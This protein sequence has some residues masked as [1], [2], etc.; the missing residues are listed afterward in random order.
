[1]RTVAGTPTSTGAQV[2]DALRWAAV[3]SVGLAMSA[4]FVVLGL[5]L[6]T[7]SAPFTGA[8][9]TKVMAG[10]VLAPAVA[11]VVLI[12]VHHGMHERLRWPT[13][14]AS[15]WLAALLWSLALAV[16]DGGNGLA[17]PVA[18][19]T[20]YLPDARSLHD[21]IA[22]LRAFVAQSGQHTFATRQHPPGPVLLLWAVRP[23]G[24][25]R[26]TTIGIAITM[27]GALA[28]P[29]VASSVRPLC[30]E[31]AARRLV[32]A[33]A[34]APWAVW[35]AVSMD[36]VTSSLCAGFICCGV[37][38]GEPHRSRWWAVA[39]GLL[40]GVAAL[41]SYSVV[42]MAAT[43]IAVWFVR[44]RPVLNV[45]AGLAA[46]VPLGLARAA[47]FVWPDGLTAAQV[48]FSERIGPQRSWGL[49]APLDL[50]ILVIACGP[51]LAAAARKWRRTPGWPFLVG[52]VLAVG[53]ALGSGLSRGEVERSWLPFF[54]W[55]LVPV[56]APEVPGG[57]PSRTPV[58][59][60]GLGAA[61]GVVIEAVLLTAW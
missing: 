25:V 12:A 13:L 50:L 40:L 7:A 5:H 53:F 4:A 49:W 36:A 8:Y 45:V 55:L 38:A 2:R 16:V 15:G 42:W 46:L 56:V 57:D 9:R 47:G 17:R 59:L 20:E 14:L 44:R 19:P 32:P 28:V 24:L 6:G 41:F 58:L 21:P 30:G 51:A 26:P 22:F 37:L 18:D 61:V 34:L 43:L 23:L 29:L 31:R 10:S 39:A 33:L 1:M 35:T 27:I 52:A 3:V 48:D 11:G 54:P 60:V